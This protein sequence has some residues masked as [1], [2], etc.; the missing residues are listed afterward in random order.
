[1]F[2][3]LAKAQLK[4]HQGS[5]YTNTVKLVSEETSMTLVDGTP[6]ED[7]TQTVHWEGK[8]SIQYVRPRIQKA[9]ADEHAGTMEDNITIVCYLPYNAAP[10]E[11]MMVVD[12]DG[13]AGKAGAYYPQSRAPANVGG[14]N[15]Y[16]ELYIG[17][18]VNA[19]V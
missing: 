17:A 6:Q 8:G 5:L 16:W 1:M 10:T 4:R 19:D 11:G 7:V 14:L 3:A 12:V 15:V 18:T 2:P 9:I 13:V